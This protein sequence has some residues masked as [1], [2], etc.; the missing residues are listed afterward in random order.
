MVP[1]PSPKT[2]SV[3]TRRT[4]QRGHDGSTQASAVERADRHELIE[5]FQPQ[6]NDGRRSL[7]SD[8]PTCLL[9]DP[10]GPR[11]ATGDRTAGLCDT[12]RRNL[13]LDRDSTPLFPPGDRNPGDRHPERDAFDQFDADQAHA[14]NM[15]KPP[16]Q[17]R[18]WT[19]GGP[20]TIG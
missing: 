19:I 1:L 18:L 10:L 3:V 11:C 12:D 6:D 7:I 17:G 13:G 15:P 4:L 14:P 8:A 2:K 9:A 20:G 16:D 5:G